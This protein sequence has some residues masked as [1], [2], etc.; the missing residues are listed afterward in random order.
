MQFVRVGE[1]M[2]HRF[3]HCPLSVFMWN[4]VKD[5]LNWT[6]LLESVDDF[7]DNFLLER[8]KGK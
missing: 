3:F 2:N 4:V 7:N 8:G 5:G 6:K 1:T